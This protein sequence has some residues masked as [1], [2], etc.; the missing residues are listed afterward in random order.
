MLDAAAETGSVEVVMQMASIDFGHEGINEHVKTDEF[1][2]VERFPTATYSG[3][4]VGFDNGSPTAVEGN[5]TMHG[6]SRPLN[7]DVVTLMCIDSHRRTNLPACGA[8]LAGSLDRADWG[9]DY[10]GGGVHE[11]WV[12]LNIQVEARVEN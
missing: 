9:V 11:T 3:K 1:F 5:L 2:D 10:D 7:L 8:E 12:E 6:V 4:L